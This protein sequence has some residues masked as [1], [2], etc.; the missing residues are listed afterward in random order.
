MVTTNLGREH[1]THA[2]SNPKVIVCT[3]GCEMTVEAHSSRIETE[4]LGWWSW[5]E[6][7]IL[8]DS[9]GRIVAR[10]NEWSWVKVV[11]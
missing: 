5:R 10:F 9:Y 8:T 7:L 11:K 3:N 6:V 1:S 2:H 4:W